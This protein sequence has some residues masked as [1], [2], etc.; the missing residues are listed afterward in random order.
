MLFGNA[1][2]KKLPKPGMPITEVAQAIGA[3]W[4]KVDDVTKAKFQKQADAAKVKAQKAMAKYKNGREYKAYLAA[5]ADAKAAAKA[6]KKAAKKA[7]KATKA[8]KKVAKR[9]KKK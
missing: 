3:A 2:R 1:N 9:S 8:T 5:V 7:A 4:G 6:E